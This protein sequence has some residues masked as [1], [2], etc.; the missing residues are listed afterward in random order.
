MN[1][2]TAIALT[3][4][5]LGAG[6]APTP[7]DDELFA[8][9]ERVSIGVVA[10]V[11]FCLSSSCSM[12]QPCAHCGK[13]IEDTHDFQALARSLAEHEQ[14]WQILGPRIAADLKDG[15]AAADLKEGL[16]NLAMYAPSPATAAWLE[17]QHAA[18]PAA[19]AD[20]H[21]IAQVEL[22]SKYFRERL[23]ERAAAGSLPAAAY[24]AYRRDPTGI[25]LLHRAVEEGPRPRDFALAGASLRLLGETSAWTAAMESLRAQVLGHIDEEQLEAA[26]TA[27]LASEFLTRALGEGARYATGSWWGFD[28]DAPYWSWK[29]GAADPLG[30]ELKYFLLSREAWQP[31]AAEVVRRIRELTKADH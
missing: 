23:L 31:S 28:V 20:G 27:T 14:A 4:G 13:L 5:S 24:L 3:V 19:F 18:T 25:D 30:T 29:A 21:L 15:G 7:L 26:R 16:L 9:Y 1:T 6:S 11:E 10:P 22:G 12:G 2:L 17:K 8:L